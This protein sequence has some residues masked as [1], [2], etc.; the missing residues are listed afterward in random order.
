MYV[1]WI[2]EVSRQKSD[3][4]MDCQAG[5][6]FG[7]NLGDMLHRTQ[8]MHIG[9]H[10]AVKVPDANTSKFQRHMEDGKQ[11]LYPGYSNFSR[12]SFIIRLYSL[13][14]V[15]GIT[16]AAFGDLLE[17]LREAFPQAHIP[18]SFNSAN[19]IIRDIGLDYEK[20]HA[21]PNDCMLYRGVMCS[22]Y[23]F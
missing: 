11:P 4:K 8:G 21:C 15:H 18:L 19:N 14:C 5:T 22:K 6:D 1:E 10:E 9:E 3:T 20:I 23:D 17:F 12:L 2:C 16:E 7:D 13:K